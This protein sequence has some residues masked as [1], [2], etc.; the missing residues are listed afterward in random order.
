MQI[1]ELLIKLNSYIPSLRCMILNVF[2]SLA[3]FGNTPKVDTKAT[4]N[5]KKI[6]NQFWSWCTIPPL[7]KEKEN[8]IKLR[9]SQ[10]VLYVNQ[11]GHVK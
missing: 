9:E 4:M 7:S 8:D 10:V 2:Y 1:I 6:K 5:E 11:R 3:A